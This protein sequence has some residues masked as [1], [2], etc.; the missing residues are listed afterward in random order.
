MDNISVDIKSYLSFIISEERFAI[1]AKNINSIIEMVPITKVPRMPEAM[2]GII[3]L[4]EK[5]VP[6]LDVRLLFGMEI[7]LVTS[8]SCI[9]VVEKEA[10]G[11]IMPL[12][13]LVDSVSEVV[14]IEKENI[15]PTPEIGTKFRNETIDGVFQSGGEFI[16]LLNLNELIAGIDFVD[17]NI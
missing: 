9:I 4:R 17:C 6:V 13:L 16:M 1:N 5:V 15:L 2:L 3:S 12:G 11:A 7:S 8:S 14:E 10:N